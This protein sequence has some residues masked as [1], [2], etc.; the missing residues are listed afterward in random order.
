[1][2]SCYPAS[3]KHQ[4][5]ILHSRC[6]LLM[7]RGVRHDA[8]CDRELPGGSLGSGRRERDA[9]AFGGRLI[10]LGGDAA[11]GHQNIGLQVVCHSAAA[12]KVVACNS[13]QFVTVGRIP[14]M[15]TS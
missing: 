10:A 3:T 5:P 2:N 9:H 14:I 12:S 4:S 8:Y 15:S 1:G 11:D 6:L 7:V 13:A